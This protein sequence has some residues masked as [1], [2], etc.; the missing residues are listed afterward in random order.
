MRFLAAVFLAGILA[1]A[2][3]ADAIDPS[4]TELPWVNGPASDS[5]YKVSQS[6]NKVHV[7]ES[8]TISCPYCHRNAPAVKKL[9]QYYVELA[10]EREGYDRVQF[11]DLCLNASVRDCQSWTDQHQPDYPVVHDKNR[12]VWSNLSQAN[13]IPQTFVTNCEGELIQ[14]TI[15]QWDSGDISTIK[16]AIEEALLTEC[17][18]PNTED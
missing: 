8:F 7:W 17:V 3:Q 14:H 2:A 10:A 16:D 5:V 11:L 18:D 6:Y 15:G 12:Y 9:A 13:S 4:T 1:S